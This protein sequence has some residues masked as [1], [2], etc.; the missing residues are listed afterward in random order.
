[1]RNKELKSISKIYFLIEKSEYNRCWSQA[2]HWPLLSNQP[3]D[4]GRPCYSGCSTWPAC[5]E[6]PGQLGQAGPSGRLSLGLGRGVSHPFCLQPA[7][8]ST[9]AFRRNAHRSSKL[10]TL[11]QPFTNTLFMEKLANSWQSTCHFC[12]WT[13]TAPMQQPPTCGQRSPQ[14]RVTATSKFWWKRWWCRGRE[15]LEPWGD[16]ETLTPVY[17]SPSADKPFPLQSHPRGSGA[18]HSQPHGLSHL[19]GWIGARTKR[20]Q[21]LK[22]DSPGLDS[23]L[24]ISTHLGHVASPPRASRTSSVES[25]GQNDTSPASGC[26]VSTSNV[27]FTHTLMCS[28]DPPSTELEAA[29]TRAGIWNLPAFIAAR[30]GEGE[31]S[32]MCWPRPLGDGPGFPRVPR[33]S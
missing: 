19:T 29:I 31:G 30:P 24:T 15:W 13:N 11:T 33:T 9:P 17:S 14:N 18:W 28:H 5:P 21:A 20:T 3:E 7:Y 22:L 4:K 2:L 8:A 1:M 16:Q 23:A 32:P 26:T 10:V 6:W 12:V 25:C 27:K